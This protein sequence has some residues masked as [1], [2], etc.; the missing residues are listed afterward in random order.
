[1]P[2]L[3]GVTQTKALGALAAMLVVAWA[4]AL[5]SPGASQDDGNDEALPQ[6]T[7]PESGGG[8]GVTGAGTAGPTRVD[9]SDEAAA[10]DGA[11][12][13][14]TEEP[15]EPMPP[16]VPADEV[17]TMDG[18]AAVAEPAFVA[19][20]VTGAGV[21]GEDLGAAARIGAVASDAKVLGTVHGEV[22]AGQDRVAAFVDPQLCPPEDA[23]A[24]AST[25]PLANADL[26]DATARFEA[27]A[28]V[29]APHAFCPR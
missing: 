29:E 19:T 16:T 23:P 3:M 8:A 17:H 11:V 2:A 25:H 15:G 13:P 14:A 10:E 26:G 6:P 7:G 22:E 9:A 21:A 24:T 27:D 18:E 1:M 28:A 5:A 20:Q 12:D 4:I